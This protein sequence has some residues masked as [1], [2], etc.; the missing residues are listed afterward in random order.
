MVGETLKLFEVICSTFLGGIKLKYFYNHVVLPAPISSSSM[1]I[2]S[3]KWWCCRRGNSGAQ[4]NKVIIAVLRDLWV[5][6][7]LP[8]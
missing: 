7:M 1:E 5:G 3:N 2:D 4:S 6:L 8:I